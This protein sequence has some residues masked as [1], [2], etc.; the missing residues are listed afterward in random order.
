MTVDP[1]T[2]GGRRRTRRG[3]WVGVAVLLFLPLQGLLL[4]WALDSGWP[5]AW[6]LW[7]LFIAAAA[8]GFVIESLTERRRRRLPDGDR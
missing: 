6:I 5:V 3:L 7:A 1:S 4:T 2:P 8:A